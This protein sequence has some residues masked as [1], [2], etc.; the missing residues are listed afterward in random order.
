MKGGSEW[1]KPLKTLELEVKI[2]PGRF[3]F[4]TNL[5]GPSNNS[6]TASQRRAEIAMTM[7]VFHYQLTHEAMTIERSSKSNSTWE[8]VTQGINYDCHPYLWA[9]VNGGYVTKEIKEGSL[10]SVSF[11]LLLVRIN[12]Y[13]DILFWAMNSNFCCK[14]TLF[15]E[16]FSEKKFC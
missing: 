9:P 13:Y 7:D 15:H 4:W 10:T 16:N 11:W 8:R 3:I 5:N 2:F 14:F 12:T 6:Q 1:Q